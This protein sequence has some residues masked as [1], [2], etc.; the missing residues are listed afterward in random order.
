MFAVYYT[1]TPVKIVAA[2]SAL[3]HDLAYVFLAAVGG[4]LL[5][6]ALRQPL[7]L[8][9]VLGGIVI[10][11]FTPGPKLTD[12]HGLELL[13]EIGVILLMYSVGIE[14]SLDDLLKVKWVAL[15]GAPLG[16]FFTVAVTLGI[17]H[18]LHWT[19]TQSIAMGSVIAVASTMVLS[20]LLIDRGELQSEQGRIMIG[21]TLMEDFVV[22]AL[23]VLL[24]AFGTLGADRMLGIGMAL[25]KALAVLIPV[26]FLAAK[27]IPPLLS[28]AARAWSGELFLLITLALGFA[29]AVL[30][31]KLGL[32]LALG[33][34]LA[35]MI[36]SGSPHAH[37]ALQQLLP[38]RDAFVALFFVTI[39]ALI[40]PGTIWAHPW[41]L[42]VL[43]VLILLGKFVLW[44]AVVLL[45]RYPLQTALLVAIG[46]TQI[47]EFSYVLVRAARDY[48]LV[49]PEMYNATL[50]ASLLSILLNA[51]LVR[52]APGWMRHLPATKTNPARA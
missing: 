24:P 18:L 48:Q 34:F 31:E 4:G 20:R 23:T 49:S 28:R 1:V 29:T 42:V 40:A 41:L 9:Y 50:A 25:G 10:G 52:A 14:F 21:I 13:A 16:I 44:S 47:G 33:A 6:R 43:L 38:L 45:F 39:G 36:I 46:L 26:V 5:A 30:T 2:E 27:F 7:I 11:P 51:I 12:I 3:Y 35:G 22:V 19:I 15:L 8:G 32:S 37:D 17:G